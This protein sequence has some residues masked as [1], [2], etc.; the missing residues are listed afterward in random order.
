LKRQIDILRSKKAAL[1][2]T[3][4][5]NAATNGKIMKDLADKEEQLEL[6]TEEKRV[7]SVIK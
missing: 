3:D 6:F 1:P 7:T 2:E 5:R 4:Q